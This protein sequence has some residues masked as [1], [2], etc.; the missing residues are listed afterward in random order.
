MVDEQHRN[1]RVYFGRGLLRFQRVAFV[2]GERLRFDEVLLRLVRLIDLLVQFAEDSTGLALSSRIAIV[3]GEL[4]MLLVM[5]NRPV[6]VPFDMVD[7]AEDEVH[8]RHEDA[9]SRRFADVQCVP[10]QTSTRLGE[11][12]RRAPRRLPVVLHGSVEVV[13]GETRVGEI[14]VLAPLTLSI[15]AVSCRSQAL[16]IDKRGERIVDRRAYLLTSLD[17]CGCGAVRHRSRMQWQGRRE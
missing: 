12:E 15:S 1:E 7:S 6:V 2:S 4:Q 3:P 5:N 9:I 10:T 14:D 17:G 11:R 13:A 8:L 16:D